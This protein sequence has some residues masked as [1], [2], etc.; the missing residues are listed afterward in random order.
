MASKIIKGLTVEIGGD[1]TKLG[2]ALEGVD[3][4]SRN[5]SSELGEIN[6][7]LKMD[8]GNTDLPTQRQMV[9]ADAIGNTSKK[10]ATLK[11]A[12][13]Q[14]QEQ[15]KRG[16]VS[17]EQV[18]ALQREIIA[19]EKKMDSYTKAAK[20]TA[21]ALKGVGDESEKVEESTGKLGAALGNA[22]KVGLQAVAAAATAA[23][24]G[25]IA[26][27]ES[28]REYRTEMGKLETAFTTA[29]HS[30]E[31]ATET[32]KTL[33]GVLGETDQAVEAANHLAQLASTEEELATWTDIATGVYATFGASLPIEG[34]TEAANETA[35]TGA[36]TGALAD[37]L[38]WAGVNEDEFQASLDACSS[39]QERQALITETLN[40]LY[41][42][43][44][45]KYR[46]TNAEV[47]R[48]NEANEAW[49]ASLAE[50]GGVIEPII[51]D[52]KM[53]GAA[54]LSDLVPG[55]KQLA[56]SFRELLNGDLTAAD[57]IGEALSG[58]ITGL[59]TKVTELL[60]TLT[61]VAVSLVTTLA[62][63][64]ISMLPQLIETGVQ[65][66][67]ALIT[68]ISQ[69]LPQI[70]AAFV[71][72]LPVFI[73]ALP[74]MIQS[75]VTA[76]LA[77]LPALIEGVIALTM[78]IVAALPQ[79]LDVLLPMLPEI[80][81]QI[82]TALA[83]QL[84]VLV[85]AVIQLGIMLVTQVLPQLI[86]AIG[87]ALPKILKALVEGVVGIYQ[88]VKKK[89]EEWD[90]KLLE[91]FADIG[92]AIKEWAANL[93]SRFTS[94]VSKL[95]AKAGETGKK[96]LDTVVKFFSQL[97]G[98]VWEWLKNAL[99]KVTTWAS[100]LATKARETGSKF[101]T[102]IV[103]FFK[104]LPG[105][106]G[107]WLTTALGKVTT[108]AT[109]LV[110]KGKDAAKRLVSS[111]VDGIKSLPSKLLNIGRD[112]VTGLWNGITNK[113]SWLKQKISGFASSV[114]DSIKGFFGVNSPSKETAW[115]GDML[116]QGL[117]KGVLDNAKDPVKAMQRVSGSVLDA[118][119]NGID[120]LTLDRQLSRPASFGT[121]A[122]ATEGGLA[123]KLD[124][125]LAAIER[126]Q[127]L[128]IDGD[129]LV[130]ATADRY[131]ATLGQRRALAARG[132]R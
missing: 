86:L 6:R 55:V 56:T 77:L 104:Q 35:K 10:L 107:S 106:I 125:I 53:M 46:E 88:A 85:D 38:N 47:I 40:G 122:A 117:A 130:G 113:L 69:A 124:K 1:T 21:D 42:E 8:P 95:V 67:S 129:Q 128:T 93:W 119:T 75:L 22:A 50:I 58:I 24:T 13:K 132:A 131:D 3:K 34:L 62:T 18:R 27:A 100:N 105:K 36:L 94:W 64:L 45:D 72:A 31:A 103:A 9:L 5:L 49:T 79:I 20:E 84:P 82:C 2:K 11:E 89:L 51:T 90:V 91:W 76:L 121:A 44:A 123:D 96:F 98:K 30:S 59:L 66:V 17:E 48:A 120:G 71:A 111:V 15:F 83:E 118:A 19:T 60:P 25:L 43:A 101:L 65:M 112:L 26:A 80:I 39:E 108:W 16:E 33:Q 12:E 109:N 73:A 74:G 29:G 57:G 78:G 115:I 81:T 32:Y 63:T 14:V 68:G 92:A 102:S 7:L 4:Q 54:L 110:N 28:T 127:I 126:G 61:Q 99:S 23:V 116:D 97:P 41:S 87:K 70:V 114:L 37:A 52:V